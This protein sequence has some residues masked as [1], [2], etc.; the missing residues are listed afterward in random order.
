MNLNELISNI[1][2]FLTNEEQQFVKK[3]PTVKLSSL[4]DHTRWI[5]QNLVR[6]GVYNTTAD[7]NTLVKNNK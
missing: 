2:I 6:K 1:K 4:D 5:A 3:Y 7:S